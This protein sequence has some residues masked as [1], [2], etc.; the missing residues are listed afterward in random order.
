[1]TV[2]RVFVMGNLP[3]KCQ[4]NCA[5]DI[6]TGTRYTPTHPKFGKLKN[7]CDVFFSMMNKK[8]PFFG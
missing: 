7:I 2:S 6:H 8:T 3:G 1:M 4:I 5:T